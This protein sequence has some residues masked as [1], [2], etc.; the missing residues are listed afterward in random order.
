MVVFVVESM[1]HARPSVTALFSVVTDAVS[2]APKTALRARKNVATT[3]NTAS[4]RRHVV[5]HVILATRN[6]FGSAGIIDARSCAGSCAIVNDVTCHV[7]SYFHAG[8]LVSVSVG[9][10]ARRS[11]ESVTKTR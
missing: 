11:V 3:V 6:A 2:R 8:I 5:N 10:Y 1:C 7:Q 4:A 9:K